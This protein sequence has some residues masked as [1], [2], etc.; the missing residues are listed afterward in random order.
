[1]TY[2]D[3]ILSS[4]RARLA[5]GR[6]KVTD[7][8]LEQ[9]VA[10]QQ[11]P[12][13]FRAALERAARPA[14]IAEIKRRSPSKGPLDLDL[15][16]QAL[17]RRYAEGGAAALS[18]LTEPDHFAGSLEDLEAARVAGLPVLRKDFIVDPF[19]VFEARAAGADAVL[20]IVRITDDLI[21]LMKTCQSLGM[22]ALVE[23]Y[24]QADLAVALDAGADLVGINHR[25]LSTFDVDPDRTARLRPSIPHGTL[26][27]SLSGVFTRSDVVRLADAGA[28]AVLVGESVVT[29]DDPAAHLRSLIGA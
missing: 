19:Q 14:L 23:V 12:R 18:V 7:D 20:L 24:D 5:D 2:L 6:S 25:D 13:G 17:A 1:M 29:A 4:T 8:V 10:S 22:D 21:G 15:D 16:A 28:D 9:R 26:V 27:V 11:P 3:D